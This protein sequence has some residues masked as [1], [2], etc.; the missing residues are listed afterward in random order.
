VGQAAEH[1]TSGL[2]RISGQDRARMPALFNDACLHLQA[3]ESGWVI[4]TRNVADFDLL[5]QLLPA[6]RVLFYEQA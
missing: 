2:A 6:G 3:L 4:L 5:D 1:A